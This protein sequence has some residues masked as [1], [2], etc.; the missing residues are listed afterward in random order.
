MKK[1]AFIS[2]VLC[3]TCMLLAASAPGTCL[4]AIVGGNGEPVQFPDGGSADTL[5]W[6]PI[7]FMEGKAV[8]GPFDSEDTIYFSVDLNQNHSIGA[9]DL[10]S[11]NSDDVAFFNFNRNNLEFIEL[12][13]KNSPSYKIQL[14]PME[15]NVEVL[16][17]T[18][19]ACPLNVYYSVV[20]EQSGAVPIPGALY[21]LSS[22][23]IALIGMRR[24]Q[25]R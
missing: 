21:L 13:W 3:L 6:N 18:S 16:Y 23:L 12:R 5:L 1:V 8:L 11:F 15:Q 20:P 25:R 4:A 10:F 9:G 17:W 19:Y 2:L 7:V 14:I 22:G 24:K